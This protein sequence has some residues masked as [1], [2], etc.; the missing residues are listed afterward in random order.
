M[1]AAFAD[2]SFFVA[3]LNARDEHHPAASDRM[4]RTSRMVTTVW[5]LAE[6]GNYL[7][8]AANR[9]LF[10]PFVRALNADRRLDVRPATNE[11]FDAAL[12][13]YDERPDKEW[14][15]TDCTSFVTMRQLGLIDALT[16]DYHFEQSGFRRL[17]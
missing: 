12:V 15:L 3:F 14:S 4:Q 1:N 9:R 16:A 10:V 8:K 13:L 11:V 7:S 2:T 6:L 5:V 17:L